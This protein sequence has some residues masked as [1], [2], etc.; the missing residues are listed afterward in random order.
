MG[1]YRSLDAMPPLA[2]AILAARTPDGVQVSFYDDRVEVIPEDDCPDL[3]ALTVE[4]FTARRAYE[5]AQDYKER[6][7]TVVMGGY[8]P[9]MVPDEALEYADAI[10]IGDAEGSWETLLQDFQDNRLKR[11]YQG[12]NERSLE[13]VV[14]D[15]TIFEGKRYPPIEPVQYGRGCRFACEFCSIHAFYKNGVRF[16]PVEDV[17]NE[18]R[19]LDKRKLIFF[20]DDNLFGCRDS[21]L[22]LLDAVEPL[23]VRWA[24]QIS[25]DVARDEELMLRMARAGCMVALIGFESLSADNLRQMHKPWNHVA[26]EYESV[27]KRFHAMGI[28]VY[29][30]FVF[31]YDKDTVETIESTLKFAQQVMLDIANFNPLT[32]TP[33]TPLYE[34]LLEEGRLLSE[35]WWVD[36]EFRYG[37]AIFSPR[38]VTPGEFS[39]KCFEAK[40]MFYSWGSILRRMVFSKAGWNLYRIAIV[41]L[42][43]VISRKEVMKKQ[44]RKLG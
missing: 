20:V 36:P 26:G 39:D 13:G 29:G 27:V 1:N 42:A 2:L 11:I 7:V 18:I 35:K 9:T 37:D 24:C 16:R 38:M 15:R 21:L 14:L 4:T 43:N 41:G 22:A 33:G 32:P 23:G 31:G 10:V 12:G 25:I 17:V 3:V 40:K 6:N 44:Y 8:H 19:Q 28:A 30:T 5:I 34:R